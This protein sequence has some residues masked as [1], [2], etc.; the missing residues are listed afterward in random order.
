MLAEMQHI[1]QHFQFEGRYIGIAI[2]I[3]LSIAFVIVDDF[4]DLRPQ[5]IVIRMAE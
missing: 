4:F 5:T 1:A 3:A 2:G